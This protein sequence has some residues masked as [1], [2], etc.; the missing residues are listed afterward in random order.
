[1]SWTI[2]EAAAVMGM[3]P[4]EVTAVAEV[5]DYHVVST[6]DG[7]KTIVTDAGK[8]VLL[9]P[10]A[11]EAEVAA[12]LGITEAELRAQLDRDQA[13]DLAGDGEPEQIPPGGGE[14]GGDGTPEPVPDVDAKELV[15]WVGD[16]PD[17][18]V[19]ALE[20]EQAREKGPRSTVVT[21]LEKVAQA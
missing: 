4:R 9:K 16:D 20:A 10:D 7:Q 2:D 6:H 17:R 13:V 15:A 14:N 3:P 8:A 1:M 11:T 12:E 21:A 18:A 19:R 5:G